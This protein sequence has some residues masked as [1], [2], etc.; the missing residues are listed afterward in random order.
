MKNKCA[1]NNGAW[2][3]NLM[4]E[5][6]SHR[7]RLRN[8]SKSVQPMPKTGSRGV[9]TRGDRNAPDDAVL[10]DDNDDNDDVD[11]PA[12]KP[13]TKWSTWNEAIGDAKWIFDPFFWIFFRCFADN[14]IDI[15]DA[16]ISL[17]SI[18]MFDFIYQVCIAE[19]S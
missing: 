8:E 12:D 13:F 18:L 6:R 5:P 3:M 2:M 14:W 16:G 11:V 4:A 1:L 9:W 19:K 15:S 17:N 7:L 10:F